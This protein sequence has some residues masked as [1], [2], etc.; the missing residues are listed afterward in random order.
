LDQ[1]AL[2]TPQS[3]PLH[4][5]M[6]NDSRLEW[7]PESIDELLPPAQIFAYTDLTEM[8]Q[9]EDE[10][11]RFNIAIHSHSKFYPRENKFILSQPKKI[12]N[13][14]GHRFRM[15]GNSGVFLTTVDDC[16]Y[17]WISEQKK[18]PWGEY[19]SMKNI[20]G[21]H[22]MIQARNLFSTELEEQCHL[23][24]GLEE[25]CIFP[26]RRGVLEE[27][28]VYPNRMVVVIKLKIIYLEDYLV[29]CMGHVDL[30]EWKSKRSLVVQKLQAKK[31]IRY[32]AEC[33]AL[34]VIKKKSKYPYL[35]HMKKCAGCNNDAVRYCSRTCQRL[36]W[37]RE[38]KHVCS[39]E[40]DV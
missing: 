31:Q 28:Y 21:I 3:D 2:Y 27:G 22:A 4:H 34:G 16:L 8:H 18:G 17:Y 32:C 19:C 20:Y 35:K 11:V 15:I 40:N 6:T 30:S 9:L 33:G 13:A 14:P 36:H 23:H 38:H 39:H 26:C 1:E 7:D 5:N 25:Q 29:H 10:K 24:F 37:T 12:Y